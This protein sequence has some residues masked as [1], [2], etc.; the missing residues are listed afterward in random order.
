MIIK[1]QWLEEVKGRCTEIKYPVG[2]DVVPVTVFFTL[3][4]SENGVFP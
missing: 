3:N 4:P 1:G 2:V